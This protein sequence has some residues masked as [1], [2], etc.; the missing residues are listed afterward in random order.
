MIQ[1][2]SH[3]APE[4][5]IQE[6]KAEMLFPAVSVNSQP[7]WDGD[8]R[9]DCSVGH[10]Q[11]NGMNGSSS[12]QIESRVW[13]KNSIINGGRMPGPTTGGCRVGLY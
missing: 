7:F 9:P 11:K 1:S 2:P 12:S 13:E 5:G 3:M 6:G 4:L 8:S 10:T